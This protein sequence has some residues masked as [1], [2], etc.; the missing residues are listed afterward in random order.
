[1]S[2]VGTLTYHECQV[3]LCQKLKCYISDELQMFL[4]NNYCSQIQCMSFSVDGSYL[5]SVGDYR[6]NSIV[7]WNVSDCSAVAVAKVIPSASRN[8]NIF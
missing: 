2:L 5:V 4:T 6:E 7:L 3:W 1:M 8:T